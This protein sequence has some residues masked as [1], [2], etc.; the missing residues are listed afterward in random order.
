[1]R[2]RDRQ[3]K[4]Q[5]TG[6]T[7]EPNDKLST[8][9]GIMNNREQMDERLWNYIDGLGSTEERS[10]IKTLIETQGDWQAA[11]RELLE[12]S[13][14]VRNADLE[15]PSMRFAKNVME[16]ISKYHIAPATRSYINKKIIWGIGGF[17]IITI[18]GFIIYA[19]GQVQWSSAAT[20]TPDVLSQY[21]SKLDW[22]RF[23]TSAY[24]NVFI[25]INVVL[26][27]VL[28]DLYLQRRKEQ[29]KSSF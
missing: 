3:G 10:A 14:L 2:D 15:V 26:G 5:W 16:E 20:A 25:L 23:F 4:N 28:L 17:F 19:L 7:P 13:Q 1:M 8:K 27:L 29:Q 24:T 18:L 12:I 22:S 9:G 11:H 6:D 21:T